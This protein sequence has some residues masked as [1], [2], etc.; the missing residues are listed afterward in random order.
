MNKD[1]RVVV[2]QF[3][4]LVSVKKGEKP[5]GFE[6]DL[7]EATAKELG[8]S[9]KYKVLPFQDLLPSLEKGKADVALA[10]ITINSQREQV[11]DFSHPTLDSGLLILINR[12][13]NGPK[14]WSTVA[15]FLRQD[16]GRILMPTILVLAFII[17]FSNLLYFA[18]VSAKTFSDNYWIGIFEA[19]WLVICSMSTD[20]FGDYVPN[21][22]IG[23]I[24]TTGIILGGV[25]IFGLLIAQMS[26]FFAVKK[27]Q[28]EINGPLDLRKKMVGTVKSSTSVLVLRRL[29][30][31]VVLFS[32]ID[33]A[34]KK[35]SQ[36]EVSAVVFDA[37]VLTQFADGEG[38]DKF[39]IVGELFDKQRYGIAFRNKS[40]L[41]EGAN[42]ALL[43]LQ[44]SGQYD[45][46]Y[47]KW[48]GED[49][50]L[51]A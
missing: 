47:K 21:T 40:N 24:I 13:G 51:E 27:I 31:N 28:G 10:G 32:T 43:R 1:V 42:Q 33:Q 4:P 7:W 37:P 46:I 12:S 6:I 49:T 15:A 48:F 44:E 19:A 25:A 16:V 45:L 2:S 8:L 3:S 17:V 26:A 36:G 38:A 34:Y 5:S 35:L 20:S 18:E 29:G 23:R 11:V 41:R 30:A 14:W 50:Q 9:S 39:M 22:P